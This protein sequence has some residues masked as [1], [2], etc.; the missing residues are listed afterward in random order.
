[1]IIHKE[2]ATKP[3]ENGS[4]TKKILENFYIKNSFENHLK[5][6]SQPDGTYHHSIPNYKYHVTSQVIDYIDGL[7]T[8]PQLYCIFNEINF[9][10][11]GWVL[12]YTSFDDLKPFIIKWINRV[13]KDDNDLGDINNFKKNVS[14]LNP[15]IFTVL[16]DL[17]YESGI[18]DEDNWQGYRYPKISEDEDECSNELKELIE[19]YSALEKI[20]AICKKF[21]HINERVAAL[22]S[23]GYE[24]KLCWVGSG[25]VNSTFYKYYKKEIRIQIAASK[26]KGKGDSK[27][28]SALCAVIP[29][30][31]FL[32]RNCVRVSI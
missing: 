3:L 12:D 27:N 8:L 1:M 21:Y 29:Y 2:I 16:N 19:T 9:E 30:P 7:F 20:E 23:D 22:T 14:E 5:S 15:I 17:L 10:L 6:I 32:H 11:G 31:A 13:A 26:F 4:S 18:F 25:G 28:K 24:V